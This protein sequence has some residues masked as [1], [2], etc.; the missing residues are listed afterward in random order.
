MQRPVDGILMLLLVSMP[1]VIWAASTYHDA[2]HTHG[3]TTAEEALQHATEA[4]ERF[5]DAAVV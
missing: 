3:S 5:R 4:L 2:V 1:T